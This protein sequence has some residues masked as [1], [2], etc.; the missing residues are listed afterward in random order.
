MLLTISSDGGGIEGSLLLL[1]P[2]VGEVLWFTDSPDRQAGVIPVADLIDRWTEFG[3]TDNPPNAAILD[4]TAA[5]GVVA[6]AVELSD[7]AYDETQATLSFTVTPLE[8]QVPF[9]FNGAF[10]IVIDDSDQITLNF[11]NE[12]ND[13][14]G[15]VV[16]FKKDEV[17]NPE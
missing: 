8:G 12:S 5:G 2:L 3:F 16:V 1:D 14:P 13:D 11:I 7:P 10:S 6:Q 9:D 4:Y 17:T 15:D